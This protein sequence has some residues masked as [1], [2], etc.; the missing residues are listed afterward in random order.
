M[1]DYPQNKDVFRK[2]AD[3]A[4][5]ELEYSDTTAG[6]DIAEGLYRI[7]IKEFKE[8]VNA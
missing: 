1:F 5:Y 3:N 8:E 7:F 4:K 6:I 2:I